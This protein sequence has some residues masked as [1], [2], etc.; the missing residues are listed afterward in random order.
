MR[1]PDPVEQALDD[2]RSV[3]EAQDLAAFLRHKS[4]TVVGRAAKKAAD[5]EGGDLTAELVAAFRRLMKDPAKLDKG[6]Q[7]LIHIATALAKRDAAVA[8]VYSAGIRHVQMEG[9]YGPPVDA[10]APLRAICA[11]GLVRAN[12]PEA[13]FD[14]LGLLLDKWPEARS[15]AIRAL[16]ESGKPEAELILRYKALL[17]DEMPEI[18]GECFAG[19]LRL[20]PRARALP[21]VA[22]FLERG[23]G[24][25]VEA[26]ALALGDS[27]M[28]EAFPVLA[29]AF[30]RN[31][32][33]QS[34][35]LW[36]MGLLRNDEAVGFLLE[37]LEA[38]RERTAA[39]ALQALAIY[40]GDEAIR[41][42][43]AEV[44][45]RRGGE[46]VRKVW[47]EQW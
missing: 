15:G 42:R 27:K 26:A 5:L 12:H 21:F 30:E 9:S 37:R 14:V 46:G 29:A 4:A 22:E 1:K 11:V 23:A 13:L 39:A 8:E 45:E 32:A 43:V 6:C 33:S 35:I 41:N 31:P 44:V 3:Q 28:A 47:R 10:A 7:A 16:A 19:L 25:V 2:L 36:A 24:E 38:G 34:A 17:G 40:K 20:G 18:T